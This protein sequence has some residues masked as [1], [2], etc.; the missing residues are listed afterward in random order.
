MNR[1]GN[2]KK[3]RE[4][5]RPGEHRRGQSHQG[6]RDDLPGG[7][8]ER[9]SR[10][11]VAPPSAY[12]SLALNRGTRPVTQ[13]QINTSLKDETSRGAGQTKDV[14]PVVCAGERG[15]TGEGT[16]ELPDSCQ[17]SEGGE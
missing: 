10:G 5:A 1:A 11:P 2:D 6:L 14:L 16:W 15:L 4:G 7:K 17:P 13:K 12:S 8:K 9:V 3:A